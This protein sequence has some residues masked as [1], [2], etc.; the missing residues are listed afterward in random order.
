LDGDTLK[1]AVIFDYESGS[2]YNICVRSTDDGG[3]FFDKDFTIRVDNLLEFPGFIDVPTSYWAWR[4]I[5][6]IYAAGITGGCGAGPIYCPAAPVSR[7][8]MAVFLLRGIHGG[9]YTPPAATG[10]VFDD[11][12]ADYWA[13]AWIEQLAD[14]G[15]T[16]G[17]G[18]ANYCPDLSI[19]RDQ[20]AIFLL[21]AKYGSTHIPP[22]ASGAVFDDVPAN[23]WAAGWVEQLAAEGITGGCGNGIYCPLAPVT[24]DQ[25]AVFLQRIFNLPMPVMPG[26]CPR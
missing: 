14:E 23:Y 7:A 19:T 2:S 25:M 13:A 12:P 18:N 4:Y 16:G 5:E 10:T 17:C 1:T 22:A 3:L 9:S 24:R 26:S 11:V 20:M 8:Q 21:R 6:S 15:I